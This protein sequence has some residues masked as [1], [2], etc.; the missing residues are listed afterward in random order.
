MQIIDE[1][2]KIIIEAGGTKCKWGIIGEQNKTIETKGFNP[3]CSP[4]DDF[5]HIVNDIKGLVDESTDSILYFGAGCSNADNQKAIYNVLS[6]TFNCGNTSVRTDLEGAAI[7]LF[8]DKPGIAA[9]IGTGAAAGYFDGTKIE[10]QTPSLGYLLGDEG[11]GAY[12]G[13]ALIT[14]ILRNEF[15]NNVCKKFFEYAKLTPSNLIKNI[16]SNSATNSFLASFVPFASQNIDDEQIYSFVKE[17]LHLFHQK[18]IEPLDR[19]NLVI[20][21]IGGVAFQFKDI[22]QQIYADK[23][24]NIIVKKEAFDELMKQKS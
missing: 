5:I 19:K 24:I 21:F 16:Y 6:S 14:K 22:L 10:T 12:I 13:K 20:G 1:Y 3:N 7:A 2:M 18:H 17:S 4:L 11:S 23:G 9:I 8:D 15:S